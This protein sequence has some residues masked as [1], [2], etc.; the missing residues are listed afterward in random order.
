MTIT[1][2][3]E[4]L[5]DHQAKL[6]EWMVKRVKFVAEKLLERS[7]D[8]FSQASSFDDARAVNLRKMCDEW[9]KKN[10]LPRILPAL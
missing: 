2:T 3:I 5:K 1:L 6:D 7:M 8:P 4:E 10:P 9:D